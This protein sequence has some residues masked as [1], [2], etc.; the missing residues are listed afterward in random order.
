V[1]A[2]LERLGRPGDARVAVIAADGLGLC[3]SSNEGV[4]LSLREGL[5]TSASLVVPAPWAREAAARYRGEDVGVDL[6]LNAEFDL[7]RWGP[8]THAPSLHDG[9]GGF[10]RS[11]TELWEHADPEEAHRECRAQLERAIVWGFD[12]SHLGSHLDA[13]CLRPELFDVLAELAAEFRLPLRLP[14][15]RREETAGFPLRALAAER[16]VVAADRVI[17]VRGG[18]ELER[19]MLGLD[20]G[21]TELRLRPA[22]E[23][24]ELR[25]FDPQWADRVQDLLTLTQ[26]RDL[27]VGFERMGIEIIGYRELRSLQRGA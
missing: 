21:V 24:G 1:T 14:D 10:P 18:R 2:L 19:A 6:T 4:F 5:A 9:D 7:Y 26:D 23:T 8:L 17:S 25:S 3:H 27:A 11:V 16:D 20:P 15:S 12:V 22:T 13:L